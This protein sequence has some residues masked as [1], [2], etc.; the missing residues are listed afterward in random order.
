LILGVQKPA[1]IVYS[2]VSSSQY[3]TLMVL[4]RKIQEGAVPC[5]PMGQYII[6]VM[7]ITEF[8]VMLQVTR[9]VTG[10]SPWRHGLNPRMSML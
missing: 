1:F 9:L 2:S 7:L 4:R 5:I 3:L 10:I 8:Y 6:P